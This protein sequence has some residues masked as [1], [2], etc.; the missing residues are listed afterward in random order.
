MFCTIKKTKY[1][2]PKFRNLIQSVKNKLLRGISLTHDEDFYCLHFFRTKN[3][4]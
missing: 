1:I 3:K 4:L 2:Q